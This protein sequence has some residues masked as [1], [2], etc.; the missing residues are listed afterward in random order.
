[1][2]FYWSAQRQRLNQLVSDHTSDETLRVVIGR[3]SCI[4]GGFNC[5]RRFV[6]LLEAALLLLAEWCGYRNGVLR[7]QAEPRRDHL[8]K[9]S[10]AAR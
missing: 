10:C 6:H 1:M 7:Q 9:G 4:V 8:R 2:A 5:P 3:A